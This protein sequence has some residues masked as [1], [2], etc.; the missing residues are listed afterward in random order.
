MSA[1]ACSQQLRLG[2]VVNN[3]RLMGTDAMK[4]Q[5][6]LVACKDDGVLTRADTPSLPM[7]V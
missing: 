3:T 7:T 5:K 6:V 1:L 4:R 2:P